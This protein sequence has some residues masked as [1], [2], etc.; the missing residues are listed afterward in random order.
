MV[1]EGRPST[2]FV[3]PRSRGCSASAEHDEEEVNIFVSSDHTKFAAFSPVT[4]M[5]V[6]LVWSESVSVVLPPATAAL[7]RAACAALAPYPCNE[8]WSPLAALK[9]NTVSLPPPRPLMKP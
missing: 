7:P 8:M 5:K 1:G 4:P 3:G 9:P 6:T 2:S